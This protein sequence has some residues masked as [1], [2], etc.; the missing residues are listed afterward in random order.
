MQVEQTAWLCTVQVQKIKKSIAVKLQERFYLLPPENVNI[1][2][3]TFFTT[4][5]DMIPIEETCSYRAYY[6]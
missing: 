3:I 1:S 2:D 5:S 6:K 4:K